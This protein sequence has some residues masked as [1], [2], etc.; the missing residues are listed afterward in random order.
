MAAADGYLGYGDYAK[1]AG[2]YATA[3]QKGGIDAN[4]A[5]TRLGIALTMSGQKAQAQEAFAKVTGPRAGVVDYWE[6]Y[7]EQRA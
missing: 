3:L 2:L 4:T 7:L 1:A 6:L 5:N